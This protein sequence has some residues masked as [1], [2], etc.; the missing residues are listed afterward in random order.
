MNDDLRDAL[1][2]A[3]DDAWHTGWGDSYVD[4]EEFHQSLTKAGYAVVKASFTGEKV[5][6][7]LKNSMGLLLDAA[8]EFLDEDRTESAKE[9]LRNFRRELERP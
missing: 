3:V 1:H 9:V 6:T 4:V 5:E 2:T 7:A 8:G